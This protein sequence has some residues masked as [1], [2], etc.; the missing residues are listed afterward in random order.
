MQGQQQLAHAEVKAVK[1]E[2]EKMRKEIFPDLRVAMLYGKMKSKEKD[3]IMNDFKKGKINILVSSSV[4]EVG[5]DVPNASIMMIEGAERFG[6][7]QLHQF[8]GR[9][10]RGAEQSY[11]LLFSTDGNQT[12]RLQAMV[13]SSNGFELAEEDLK[14]RGPGDLLG[15][16]QSGIPNLVL[17][18][19]ANSNLIREVREAT[20]QLVH[21]DPRL[22]KH[23]ELRKRLLEIE[24]DVHSE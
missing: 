4:I 6:L 16:Q 12:R 10:G 8:R 5:V 22:S 11:C 20:K 13:R 2:Y 15:S 17:K 3:Q 7:A 18:G 9:V 24:R 23:P 1:Q 14:I 19:M 21:E